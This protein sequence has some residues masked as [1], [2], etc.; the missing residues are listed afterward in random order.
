MVFVFFSDLLNLGVIISRFINVAANGMISF[1]S[2]LS[3]IVYMYHIFFIHS[4]VDGQFCCFHACL[5]YFHRNTLN[6][7]A[8]IL[9]I[10]DP[11][12]V[13]HR[14][15]LPF[16]KMQS[17][18]A[19]PPAAGFFLTPLNLSPHIPWASHVP[20]THASPGAPITHL[21]CRAPSHPTTL[22]GASLSFQVYY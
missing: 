17:R 7:H 4:S 22:E 19:H 14:H 2:W 5:G 18:G 1:F 3:N 11:F 8:L 13:T 21:L 6:G 15:T 10:I 9:W 16:G 20:P 12:I